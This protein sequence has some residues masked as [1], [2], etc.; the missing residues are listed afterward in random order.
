MRVRTIGKIIWVIVTV[1]VFSYSILSLLSQNI[2]S[3]GIWLIFIGAFLGVAY[4][5][6]FKKTNREEVDSSKEHPLPL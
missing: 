2:P 6:I 3:L 1:I 4:V 5:S